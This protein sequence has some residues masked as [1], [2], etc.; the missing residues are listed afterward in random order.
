MTMECSI[1]VFRIRIADSMKI[2]RYRIMAAPQGKSEIERQTELKEVAG[3]SPIFETLAVGSFPILA[4][5]DQMAE[6]LKEM[7]VSQVANARGDLLAPL[8]T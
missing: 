3:I 6:N 8:S 4:T 7:H 5:F 2:W 1:L